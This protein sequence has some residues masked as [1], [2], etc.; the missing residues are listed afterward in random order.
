MH[1]ERFLLVILV[2][3]LATC[4]A[5]TNMSAARGRPASRKRKAAPQI[6]APSGLQSDDPVLVGAGD[7]ASC[8]DLAGAQATAKL[9]DKIPGTVFAVGDLAYPDGSDQQFANCYGPTWGRFKERTRPAPGN[10]EYQGDGGASGYVRYFG[11]AAG[12]PRTA[13]YSYNLGAWHIIAL[14]SECE[15][16]EGCDAASPQLQWLREDLDRNHATCTLAYFHKPLFSSGAAH[17]NDQ[18]L[19]PLWQ[20]LYDAGADIVIGGH[21]HHYERF[22]PQD[23]EGRADS[24]HGIREFIVGTGGKNT[25]RLLAAPQPNSEVRQADTYGVL[26]LT[27]HKTS[28]DWEFIPQA[29]RTFTDSGHGICH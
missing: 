6:N 1:G 3:S 20:T 26:K 17:G 7:I 24:A 29:G 13:Y 18:T 4:Q 27:L 25:H 19:K 21:D 10:H 9:I 8:D 5:E 22:A 11:M 14:N 28:Y 12:D 16:V 23:P 15:H 2:I